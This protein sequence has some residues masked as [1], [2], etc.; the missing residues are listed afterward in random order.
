MSDQSNT[1]HIIYINFRKAP[2][3]VLPTIT[4]NTL[5]IYDL[6]SKIIEKAEQLVVGF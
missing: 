1:I 2:D 3:V 4:L 5:E 6:D